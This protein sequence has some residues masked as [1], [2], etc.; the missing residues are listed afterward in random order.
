MTPAQLSR[1]S[2]MTIVSGII[3]IKLSV[4]ITMILIV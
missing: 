3:S 4:I 1:I 2:L